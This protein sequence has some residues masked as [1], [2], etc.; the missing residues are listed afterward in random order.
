MIR[1][2]LKD[3]TLPKDR[4]T[5][6]FRGV[7]EDNVDPLN[8]GR[9]RVRIIGI[10]TGNKVRKTQ[11]DGIPT[12][13]L[14][15]A[16]PATPIFGGVSGIGMYGVPMQG[17]HVFIFF[18][19]GN[20][21]RPIYFATAP[22]I[23]Y[24]ISDPEIGFNDPD[25]IYPLKEKLYEPD[26]QSGSKNT[27]E[28]PNSF[29]INTPSGLMVE[30]DYTDGEEQIVIKHGPTGSNITFTKT[31]SIEINSSG[32]TNKESTG[33]KNIT[34]TGDYNIKCVG[35]YNI[36]TNNFMETVSGTKSELIMGGKDENIG[37]K[38]TEKANGIEFVSN[39]KTDIV[40]SDETNVKSGS[41]IN[42]E[43]KIGNIESTSLLGS[44]TETATLN[45]EANA[46]VSA[47]VTG[48]LTAELSSDMVT[49]VKGTLTQIQGSF[50]M[51][52]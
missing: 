1:N 8:S 42:I 26:W 3:Y 47:K 46:Q 30:M 14:P 37:Q 6:M 7:V 49:T 50:I 25:G 9:C 2:S 12:E 43:S 13:E 44:I 22:A 10:H 15:W 38:L 4:L 21:M 33:S 27:Y 34:I 51:I 36:L 28:Y 16:E 18:E 23:P 40:T 32:N 52:G 48:T 29:V 17:A 5:G 45:Y 39:G 35:D 11:L 31:G 24:D 20:I 19:A 41:N